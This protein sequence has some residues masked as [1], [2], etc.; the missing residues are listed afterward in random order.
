MKY[1]LKY[2]IYCS[3]NRSYSAQEANL[4]TFAEQRELN[5][6]GIQ[7]GDIRPMLLRIKKGLAHGIIVSNI[8]DLPVTPLLRS[9]ITKNLIRDIQ[10]PESID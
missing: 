10:Y 8:L 9:L 1:A 2:Y 6:V 5:V 3:P 7:Y 4:I